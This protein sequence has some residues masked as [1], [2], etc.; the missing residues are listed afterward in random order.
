MLL[1]HSFTCLRTKNEFIAQQKH[2]LRQF[3]SLTR[4]AEANLAAEMGQKSGG[5][6]KGFK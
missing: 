2:N 4:E 5:L 3:Q 6:G 1:L